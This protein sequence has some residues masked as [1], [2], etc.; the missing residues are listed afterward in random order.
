MLQQVEIKL[1]ACRLPS[2]M[3]YEATSSRGLEYK[4][5]SCPQSIRVSDPELFGCPRECSSLA[6]A[7]VFHPA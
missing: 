2:E 7:F 4:H 1:P 3:V 5:L 6:K